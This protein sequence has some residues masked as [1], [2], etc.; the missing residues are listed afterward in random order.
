[1]PV[2]TELCFLRTNLRRP[3]LWDNLG[4]HPWTG[5]SFLPTA[6]ADEEGTVCCG[7]SQTFFLNNIS[8]T[9]L[10]PLPRKSG[11]FVDISQGQLYR[12]VMLKNVSHLVSVE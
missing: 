7:L 4:L 11:P 3:R 12:D 2:W 8:G 9:W 10:C 6:L 5:T 1:M